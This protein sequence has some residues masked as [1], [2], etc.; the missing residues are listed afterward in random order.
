M[1]VIRMA[2]WAVHLRDV[3]L[4]GDPLVQLLAA[5]PVES[6]GGR[7]EHGGRIITDAIGDEHLQDDLWGP[8][9]GC[10]Q[11]RTLKPGRPELAAEPWRS[12][13]YLQASL[14]NQARA[15]KEIF[16]R[17][18]LR[19]AWTV[20]RE[21]LH[22]PY[23][24]EAREVASGLGNTG[25]SGDTVDGRQEIGPTGPP[26]TASLL[27]GGGVIQPGRLR[28]SGETVFAN[29][30]VLQ[31]SLTRDID[32]ADRLTVVV[33]DP[34][35]TLLR[36]ARL[37]ERST[38]TLDGVIFELADIIKRDSRLELSFVDAA[39][40]DL[41]RPV[42]TPV[43]MGPGAG[44]RGEFMRRLVDLV[45]WVQAD[46]EP[47]LSTTEA[48]ALG[49]DETPWQALGRVAREVQWRR[50]ATAN[51]VLIGSDEWLAS[52]SEPVQVRELHGGVDH[53]D[54][55][56]QFGVP[57]DIATIHC[58]APTWAAP[59]TAAVD[60]V[61]MGWADGAWL[62]SRFHRPDI[63][64]AA[65]EVDV[66]RA[67]PALNE[68]APPAEINDTSFID[69]DLGEG[70]TFPVAQTA[71]NVVQ[72]PVSR[73]QMQWPVSARITSPFGYRIHPISGERK[74]HTGTDLGV[75]VGTQ[76]RACAEGRVVW[77]GLR[78]GYGLLVIVEHAMSLEGSLVGSPL[79]SGR[80]VS[81]YYAHLN[82]AQV[83]PGSPVLRGQQIALSGG[84]QGDPNAG[85]STGPHLHLE[86]R[87]E[88]APSNPELF[89]P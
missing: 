29:L 3:G 8:S 72:G 32:E 31:A 89:L 4:S 63:T 42:D 28:V 51:R 65:A 86:V 10:L 14:D 5:S 77:V 54:F 1:P 34:R 50:C 7:D 53:I 78:G 12:L 22:V 33:A 71:G 55:E 80:T 6:A 49:K 79:V 58:H 35:R 76:V 60:M 19:G 82:S 75:G 59:P 57:A 11:V 74:L 26:P 47:G 16:D 85:T 73:Y 88:G 67:R 24:P 48:H 13:P 62:V 43:A 9:Y 15:V 40:V 56:S 41:N 45:D 36:S 2:Q 83:R 30:D 21:G 20:I 44:T 39:A 70:F 64:S 61:D 52:R 46:I 69:G 81:T 37:Q 66:T 68:P 25:V 27:I 38:I 17:Q 23:L 84:A 87:V 18:G